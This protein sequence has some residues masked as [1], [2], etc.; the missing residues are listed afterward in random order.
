MTP[1]D[2]IRFDSVGA[3]PSWVRVGVLLD[4]GDCYHLS[5][6]LPEVKHYY[7]RMNISVSQ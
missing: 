7:V 6:P 4:T 3:W 5:Q 2:K 1:E